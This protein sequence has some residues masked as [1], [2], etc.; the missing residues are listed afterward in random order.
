M[1]YKKSDKSGLYEPSYDLAPG[2][3]GLLGVSGPPPAA[4]GGLAIDSVANSTYISSTSNEFTATINP[5]G[6]NRLLVAVL[7]I[8]RS[9]VTVS[10]FVFGAAAMTLIGSASF[11]TRFHFFYRLINPNTGSATVTATVS[12]DSNGMMGVIAF[13]G[14][15]QTTPA[16]TVASGTAITGTTVTCTVTS[17]AGEIVIG[18]VHTSPTIP[19]VGAGQTQRWS[20]V[21]DETNQFVNGSTEAGASSVTFS[22]TT[23]ATIEEAI[24]AGVGIKPA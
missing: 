22:Y 2:N 8:N 15:H 6:T 14:A 11:G 3:F 10:S 7:S 13:T 23:G 19:T 17:A 21:N 12:D 9:G 24:V 1:T 5:A 18:A 16:G 4:A 20:G